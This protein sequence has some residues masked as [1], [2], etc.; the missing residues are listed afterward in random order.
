ME[1]REKAYAKLNFGLDVLRRRED[2]Y[3]ELL[4]VMQSVSLCDEITLRLSG[5]ESISADA[6]LKYLPKGEKN[7]AVR[8]ALLFFETTGIPI[9]GGEIEIIKNIPVCAGMAGGST[10]AAAVLRALNRAFSTGLGRSDLEEMA[11]KLGSDVPFCLRGGTVLC[12]GRGEIMTDLPPI[13][14]CWAVI[15]KPP[16]SISTSELFAII[17]CGK[18]R[19]RPDMDGLI[20]AIEQGDVER[21]ARRVYNVF[22]DVLPP[23]YSEVGVIKAKLI[24]YGA[25]G[26]SMTGTGPSVFGLFKDPDTAGRAYD[27]LKKQYRECYLAVTTEKLD[28]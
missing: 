3:H 28:V 16:F 14:K 26:A 20:K 13:P 27:L 18:I 25:L 15:C 24:D 23:Q 17:D 22:E 11:Y 7:I 10:D 9:Q 21:I 1:L 8:A 12:R 4:T 19:N 6:N 5:G 2:G